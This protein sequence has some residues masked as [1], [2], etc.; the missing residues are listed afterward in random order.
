MLVRSWY[1]REGHVVTVVVHEGGACWYGRG[2]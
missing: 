1:V 2:A